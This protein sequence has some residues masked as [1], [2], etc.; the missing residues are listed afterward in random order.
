MFDDISAVLDFTV[1]LPDILEDVS[2][3]DV[4][5]RVEEELHEDKE[6]GA[7]ERDTGH[8]ETIE[9]PGEIGMVKEP[10]EAGY[11]SSHQ[12]SATTAFSS[13]FGGS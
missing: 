13:T 11:S 10:R 6:A 5:E 9:A 1:I 8:P 3:H 12:N 7:D 4:P 2:G